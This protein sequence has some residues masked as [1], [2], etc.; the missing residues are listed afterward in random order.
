MS[1]YSRSFSFT[2]AAALVAAAFSCVSA[3]ARDI[4]GQEISG[5]QQT[6]TSGTS[7]VQNSTLSNDG[8]VIFSNGSASVNVVGGNTIS[9][10]GVQS[11][12]IF[13]NS[14]STIN[15]SGQNKISS[16]GTQS[17]AIFANS[18]STIKI[19]GQNTITVDGTQSY[20]V[21]GNTSSHISVDG[22]NT[23]TLT[24]SGSAFYMNGESTLD[25]NGTNTI[26]S[27]GSAYY[28]NGSG[29]LT[30]EQGSQT[31]VTDA[32]TG[33]L[34]K[35]VTIED[36]ATVD[37]QSS[38]TGIR[39]NNSSTKFTVKG[40]LNVS[41]SGTALL[42]NDNTPE[43]S[44]LV[45]D[46]GHVTLTA[47]DNGKAIA[48][49]NTSEN[50]QID[51]SNTG[52]FTVSGD[53]SD[54]TGSYSF[55]NNST[56][57]FTDLTVNNKLTATDSTIS[58][59]AVRNN[60]TMNFTNS[61][62]N[63]NGSADSSMNFGKVESNGTTFN[64]GDGKYVFDELNGQG[65]EMTLAETE[66][67]KVII[68]SAS[69]GS[70]LSVVGTE[71]ADNYSSPQEYAQALADSVQN[72]AGTGSAATTIVTPDGDIFSGTTSQVIDGKL[73]WNPSQTRLSSGLE[74]L[75]SLTV[76]S[77]VNWRHEMN[78]LSK[79]MGELRDSPAGVGTWARVYGSRMSYGAASLEAKN[80]TLQIGA[81]VS[82]GDWKVGA[83]FNYTNGDSRYDF[84][85][86]DSE[87]YGLAI[88]GTWFIPCGAYVDLIAKYMRMDNNFSFN[89]MDGSFDNN[90]FSVSAETG[91]RFTL[92]DDALFI[93]PQ[94]GVSYGQVN[95]DSFTTG[96]DV[97]VDQDD[98]NSFLGRIGVRTGFKFPNNKGT[99]YAR[100][101]GV[102]DFDGEMTS[103]AS[104]N[105]SR[106][107]I[108]DDIGG[109]YVEY[110]V[111]AN[112]NLTDTTYTYVD[113]ERTSGGEVDED[114]RWNIGVRH[115]F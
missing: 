105:K 30:F 91:Y 6:F 40:D 14:S 18:S 58:F 65:N 45:I 100:I 64:I 63:A 49:Y 81:D 74:G 85:D 82:V 50:A 97:K 46:G 15:I 106:V 52:A 88:Y 33:I 96:N 111:G 86:A 87:S 8:Y 71:S 76:L 104:K 11:Y 39:L 56:G 70:T 12:A 17:Y 69:A 59:D 78:S 53:V 90:A 115:V 38:K 108:K 107:K 47:T 103:V 4:I 73:V 3:S 10:S 57:S 20:L 67:G 110:G 62:V 34:A 36:G 112:F 26:S 75:S 84:G 7:N 55:T 41:S 25:I 79:R 51:V 95:G 66:N 29:A 9:S 92:L 43:G 77:A 102:Y 13:A 24:G 114:Y 98:Y 23:F 94:V 44:S 1:T 54:Y 80:T 68:N 31:I 48:D 83:A 93:E 5:K 61:V 113:L 27:A 42:V 21:Y 99:I 16:S 2:V 89:G 72:Q 32:S 60:G 19:S 101:S 37:I 35:N 22:N 109:A 28:Q